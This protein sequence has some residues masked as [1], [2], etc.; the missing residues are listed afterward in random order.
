MVITI[1]GVFHL[2]QQNQGTFGKQFVIKYYCLGWILTVRMM[3]LAIPRVAVISALAA[4]MGAKETI[5][6]AGAL[7]SVGFE[8]LFDGWLGL[9]LAQ[10]NESFSQQGISPGARD[11]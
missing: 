4:I 6:P 10:S 5:D 1:F 9:L 7:F 11:F 3:L 8:I 2:K